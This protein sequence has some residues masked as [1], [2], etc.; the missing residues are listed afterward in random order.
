MASKKKVKNSGWN[1]QMDPVTESVA[2]GSAFSVLFLLLLKSLV[3][4]IP[5]GLALA[6][7][8]H[9]GRNHSKKK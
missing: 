1:K 7:A 4:A 9:Y 8:H 6:F 5:L 3:L 2:L